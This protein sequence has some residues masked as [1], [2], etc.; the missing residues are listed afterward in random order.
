MTADIYSRNK[1]SI[2]GERSQ[3]YEINFCEDMCVYLYELVCM[4]VFAR[5]RCV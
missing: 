4:H 1:N 5:V 3:A 2:R